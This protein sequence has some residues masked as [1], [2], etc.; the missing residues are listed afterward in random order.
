MAG[1]RNRIRQYTVTVATS[2]TA[3]DQRR[4]ETLLRQRGKT[5][6]EVLRELVRR[7]LDAAE[8]QAKDQEALLVSG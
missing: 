3:G 6:S 4:F 5:A 2:L 8:H 7:G 1:T